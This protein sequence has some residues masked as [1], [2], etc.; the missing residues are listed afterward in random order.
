M[1]IEI[2]EG[3]EKRIK[4]SGIDGLTLIREALDERE[5]SI[6]YWYAVLRDKEDQDCGT[7]SYDKAEAIKMAENQ[8]EDYPETYIAVIDNQNSDAFCVD[9]IEI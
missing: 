3:L 9:T 1:K 8:K 6:P 7:G 4:L 2:P 5:I